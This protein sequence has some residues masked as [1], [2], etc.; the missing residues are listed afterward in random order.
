M[1]D[2]AERPNSTSVPDISI[3]SHR[4]ALRAQLANRP[5]VEKHPVRRAALAIGVACLALVLLTVAYPTWATDL[6]RFVKT[7]EKNV[8][9]PDGKT[10]H[11]ESYRMEGGKGASSG[12]VQLKANANGEITSHSEQAGVDPALAAMKTEAERAIQSGRAKLLWESDGM[13]AYHVSLADGRAITYIQGPGA[14]WSVS[15]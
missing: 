15:Q 11:Q 9:G 4:A 7:G 10:Y 8:K 5:V 13:R 14:S 6:V 2:S 12:T 3:P 1:N